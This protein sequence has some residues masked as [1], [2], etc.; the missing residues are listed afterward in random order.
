MKQMKFRFPVIVIGCILVECF[1]T[2]NPIIILSTIVGLFAFFLGYCYDR[3]NDSM[4]Q[5]MGILKEIE[6]HEKER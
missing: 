1:L 6:N 3:Y 5:L 2:P 4:E